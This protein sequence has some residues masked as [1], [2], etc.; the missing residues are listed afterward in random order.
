MQDKMACMCQ[1]ASQQGHYPFEVPWC[2]AEPRRMT[3]AE[4]LERM[5]TL[6]RAWRDRV[7]HDDGC[8]SWRENAT[9]Y[10]CECGLAGER[11]IYD[12]LG[13]GKAI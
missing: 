12:S 10:D 2:T 6:L 8:P 4:R 3:D 7:E 11:E 9:S 5:T 1:G 13:L